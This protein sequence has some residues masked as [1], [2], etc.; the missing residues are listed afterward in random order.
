M[1]IV[2]EGSLDLMKDSTA[3]LQAETS[4]GNK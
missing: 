1:M 2:D 3:S 4:S